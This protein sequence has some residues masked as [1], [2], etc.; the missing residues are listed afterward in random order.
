MKRSGGLK[1]DGVKAREFAA[2]GRGKLGVD[3]RAVQEFIDRGRAASARSL[4]ADE[5]R[6]RE[7]A[8]RAQVSGAESLRKSARTGRARTVARRKESEGPLS[9]AQWRA[10]AYEASGGLCIITGT[11]AY[12]PDDPSFDAHHPLPKREL[13]ARGLAGFVW[14]AR[15]AVWLAER[16][17]ERQ[18]LAF[19]RVPG[20]LLP[21]A[22][23]A[24]CA[25]L[26]ALDGSEW[27]TALV[28]RMHPATGSQSRQRSRRD[29]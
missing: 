9:P 29:R 3:V 8:A 25:E 14:D 21:A 2:R 5:A 1:R 17:H 28:E 13:R 12:G 26:D 16:A 18:E 10:A 22:V 23:W 11:R 19:V 6:L 27:A 24:F 20:E 7:F 15:N 4:R